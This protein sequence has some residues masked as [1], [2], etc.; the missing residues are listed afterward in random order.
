VNIEKV[1]NKI[2][3]FFYKIFHIDYLA[4]APFINQL[5]D[6]HNLFDNLQ[7][8]IQKRLLILKI[9]TNEQTEFLQN[10]F[11]I[12]HENEKFHLIINKLNENEF[13]IEIQDKEIEHLSSI[14]FRYQYS[15]PCLESNQIKLI[16]NNITRST[17]PF[18][19]SR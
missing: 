14:I 12:L 6:L 7:K 5:R 3:S 8:K 2:F 13:Y 10:I 1:T 17:T 18:L 16:E 15:T 4:I 19:S 11:D 9:K